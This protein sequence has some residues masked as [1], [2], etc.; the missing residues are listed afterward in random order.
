[1]Y[2]C[3]IGG[4][5][6]MSS[7]VHACMCKPWVSVYFYVRLLVLGCCAIAWVR[8]TRESGDFKSTGGAGSF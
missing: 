4:D 6:G 8:R 2:L 5:T 7:Q 3:G 1:M